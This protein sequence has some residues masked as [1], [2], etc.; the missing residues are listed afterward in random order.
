MAKFMQTLKIK[1]LEKLEKFPDSG[2]DKK[3][4]NAAKNFYDFDTFF[5]APMNGFLNAEDYWERS[6]CKPFLN[7]IKIPTLLLN[8]LDDTFLSEECF[9]ITIAKDHD[10]LHLETPKYGGHVGFNSKIV[11]DKGYWLERRMYEFTKEYI[12]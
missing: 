3:T 9:P 10:F 6:S 2:L 5:T 12:K 8:A 4:I 11:G 1:A 7:K